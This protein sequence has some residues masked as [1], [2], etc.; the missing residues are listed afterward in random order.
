MHTDPRLLMEGW[1]GVTS[2]PRV[3]TV[4]SDDSIRQEPVEEVVSLR[5]NHKSAPGGTIEN[6]GLKEDIRVLEN[7]QGDCLEI[8]APFRAEGAQRFGLLVRCTADR[9]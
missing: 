3:L 5:E 8:I 1:A 6:T 9:A 2:L 4:A 7:I